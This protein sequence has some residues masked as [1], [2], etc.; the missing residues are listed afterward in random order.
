MLLKLL[1]APMLNNFK[2]ELK[3]FVRVVVLTV[4]AT[5]H[6]LTLILITGVTVQVPINNSECFFY[7]HITHRHIS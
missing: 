6:G 1:L 3:F 5:Y 2:R 4:Y 7:S